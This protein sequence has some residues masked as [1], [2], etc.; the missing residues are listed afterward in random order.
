MSTRT[1]ET[2]Q[3]KNKAVAEALHT[4]DAIMQEFD[5][6]IS[7]VYS[8]LEQELDDVSDGDEET[9]SVID[10]IMETLCIDLPDR[11]DIMNELWHTAEAISVDAN[12]KEESDEESTHEEEEDD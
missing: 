5:V 3:L 6:K 11:V 10:Y 2:H 8:M 1:I 9:R 7:N 12:E 4:I